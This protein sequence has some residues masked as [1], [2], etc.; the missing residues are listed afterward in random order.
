MPLFATLLSKNVSTLQ[1]LSTLLWVSG[2]KVNLFPFYMTAFKNACLWSIKRS[3]CETEKWVHY[4][5]VTY[6]CS[7]LPLWPNITGSR[8]VVTL[9]RLY[10]G[11]SPFKFR[12][13]YRLSW[14]FFST[15][16][17][18]TIGSSWRQVPWDLRPVILFSNWTLAVIV[19]M[20]HPLWR[21]EGSVVYKYC[22]PSP[23]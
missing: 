20:C 6:F 4:M 3:L 19:L 8:L 10:L 17:L 1:I 11:G 5:M 12:P 9:C 18:S 16:G 21:E 22:W 14:A 7:S 23:A 13:R 15:G 2:C